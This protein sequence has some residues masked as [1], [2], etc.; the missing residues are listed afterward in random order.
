MIELIDLILNQYLRIFVGAALIGLI[1]V[2]LFFKLK[3]N[4]KK[5]SKFKNNNLD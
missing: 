2:S 1:I 3:N 5:K 4:L